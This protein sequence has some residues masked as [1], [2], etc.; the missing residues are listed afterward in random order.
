MN[1]K[2]IYNKNILWFYPISCSK[3]QFSCK[4]LK[5]I[6]PIFQYMKK[7]S[8]FKPIIRVDNRQMRS[9]WQRSNRWCPLALYCSL[10]KPE[11]W[12]VLKMSFFGFQET[13]P[14]NEKLNDHWYLVRYSEPCFTSSA[15]HSDH[16]GLL[17][18]WCGGE[19]KTTEI[20]QKSTNQR[21]SHAK[22]WHN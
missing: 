5:T 6:R 15:C 13:D 8:K 20:L 2:T 12:K 3:V 18:M 19:N 4:W 1:S 11:K 7:L 10:T 9:H 17:G 16:R 21:A 22:K 14:K